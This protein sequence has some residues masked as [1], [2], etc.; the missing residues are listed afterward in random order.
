MK[1]IFTFTVIGFFFTSFLIAQDGSDIK[2]CEPNK[3]DNTLIGKYCHIDF[4]KESFG[5]LVI[6]TIE[7]NVKGK[8]MKFYEHREDNGFNNCFSKQYLIRVE[9]HKNSFTR[10]KDTK[11]DSLTSD[12]IYVTSVL[13]Y[14]TNKLLIDTTTVFKHWYYRKNISKVLIEN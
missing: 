13:N 1:T 5:G 2:Y 11:I 8:K 12:K 10:L 9:D 14:Y 7:I 3:L 6:D 4:G